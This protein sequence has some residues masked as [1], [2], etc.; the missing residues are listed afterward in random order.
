MT[1]SHDIWT[2]P[3]GMYWLIIIGFYFAPALIAWKRDHHNRQAIF[4]LN[5]LLGWTL[6]GWIGAFIWSLTTPAESHITVINQGPTTVPPQPAAYQPMRSCPACG[7][8]VPY[9]DVFCRHCGRRFVAS[10]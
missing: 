10:M 5:L 3:G 1:P 4:W 8:R 9:N 7:Q 2:N 6:L